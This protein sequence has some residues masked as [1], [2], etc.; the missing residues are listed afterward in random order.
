V[1]V[2][3][4]IRVLR[5]LAKVI[6]TLLLDH[7]LS[8][9]TNMKK[10]L[11]WIFGNSA[12]RLD[13]PIARVAHN[14]LISTYDYAV[15]R[16][17]KDSAYPDEIFSI[18][19]QLEEWYAVLIDDFESRAIPSATMRRWRTGVASRYRKTVTSGFATM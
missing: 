10:V 7:E 15:S 6:E 9:T 11:T 17:T 19:L 2:V 8:V 18:I 13:W 1:V 5:L 4:D 14:S 3:Q 12:W 16:A